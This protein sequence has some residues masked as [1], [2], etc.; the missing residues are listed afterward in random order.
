MVLPWLTIKR[1]QNVAWT[2][3][4]SARVDGAIRDRYWIAWQQHCRLFSGSRQMPEGPPGNVEDMLLTFAVAVREGQY[5]FGR[6]IQVQSVAVALRAVAQKYVLD[7]HADPRRAS[8][9]QHSL[10]LPIARLIKKFGN[11][12]PPPQPKLAVPVS[13][14]RA[15]T[16]QYS[17]GPH[18]MA[19]ANMV[20]IA[21]FYL[22]WV[23]EYTKQARARGT[24]CTV[25]LRK[26]DVRLWRDGLLLNHESGVE[27]LLLADSATIS[28]AH[29][30]NGT[31]GAVI[32][33]D[34]IGGEIC[35]V[36]ALARRV[37]NLHGMSTTTP[38]STVCHSGA[39]S[40]SISDRDVTLA[41]HWGAM[42]DCLLAKGYTFDWI[43][44]HSLRAGSAMAMKLSGATDST[45]MHIGQWTSLTYLTYIHKQIGALSAGEAW[46]MSQC[47]TFQNVG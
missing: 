5:G 11:D 30:K 29:T 35:P 20:V 2:A 43:S 13:T 27:V 15:I 33:H 38:L 17:F 42:C 22:L 19:V 46:K 34:A 21:F 37:A 32:H 12:D 8:P 14:I 23:G 16:M 25:P 36:G 45:I 44:S 10:N 41:V 40:S 39:R 9:A 28:I 18:H 1:L 3:I 24:K 6:Q 4:G 7:G 47:L 26:C 31:K